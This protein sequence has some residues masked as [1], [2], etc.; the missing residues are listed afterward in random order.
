LP[1]RPG[2]GAVTSA[3]NDRSTSRVLDTISVISV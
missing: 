2:L 1:A 3:W